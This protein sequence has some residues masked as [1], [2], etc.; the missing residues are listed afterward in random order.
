MSINRLYN[1]WFSRIEQL[2]S[3]E[4][5]ARLRNFVWLLIGIYE[6]TTGHFFERLS[7]GML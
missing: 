4:H 7:H 2:R 1:T 3:G 6:F 5:I